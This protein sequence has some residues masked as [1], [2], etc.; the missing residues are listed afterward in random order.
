M[1]MGKV[2]QKTS[3]AVIFKILLVTVL[4]DNHKGLDS[5]PQKTEYVHMTNHFSWNSRNFYSLEIE[6]YCSRET[7][8]GQA[9]ANKIN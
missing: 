7:Q 5:S 6:N 9:L 3:E 4:S 2:I 1:A 8:F